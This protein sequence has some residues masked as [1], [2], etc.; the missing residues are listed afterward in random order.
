MNC[1]VAVRVLGQLHRTSYDCVH[2]FLPVFSD[3][4]LLNQDFDYTKTTIVSCDLEELIVNLLKYELS[5]VFVK[6]F[7]NIL[8]NMRA[9]RVERQAHDLSCQHFMKVDFF[10]F[11]VDHINKLLNGMSAFLAATYEAEILS[12]LFQNMQ[13]LIA[14]TSRKQLLAEVITVIVYHKFRKM[15]FNF[16]EQKLNLSR[17]SVVQKTLQELASGLVRGHAKDVSF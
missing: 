1:V 11:E 16:G 4:C 8:N 9:L 13:S 7:Y 3:G 15:I 14:R 17:V 12:N 10:A 6:A 2:Q 5:F